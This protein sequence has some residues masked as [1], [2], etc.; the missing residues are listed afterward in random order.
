MNRLLLT[1]MVLSASWPAWASAQSQ[2]IDKAKMFSEE[3]VQ[4][5]DRAFKEFQ[6]RTK[7][8]V[9]IET[10][11]NL[12]AINPKLSAPL[13]SAEAGKVLL[14]YC[15]DRSS[16]RGVHRLF[17]VICRDPATMKYHSSSNSISPQQAR[18]VE[19]AV[20]S[21]LKKQDFDGALSGAAAVLERTDVPGMSSSNVRPVAK[22]GGGISMLWTV[23]L[24]GIGL[25]LLVG[26][27]RGLSGGGGG[28]GFMQ[29]MLGGMF[30]GMMGMWMYDSF[31]RGGGGFSGGD[32]YDAGTSGGGDWGDS[33]SSGGGDW[34][35]GGDYGAS[36]DF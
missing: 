9:V 13:G 1:S 7:V 15:E 35:G 26:L 12:Q 31:F 17:M 25:W 3:A 29:S 19:A 27:M 30:G 20:M 18:T 23:L 21:S 16:G 24:I 2:V 10:I 11:P 28:G 6:Q 8:E 14:K 36:G 34:G 4:T 32:G 5:A 33:G 22:E